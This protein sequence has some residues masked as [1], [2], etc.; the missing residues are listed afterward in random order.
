MPGVQSCKKKWDEVL[1][2]HLDLHYVISRVRLF[3][4][5]LHYLAAKVAFSCLS[6]DRFGKNFWELMTSGQV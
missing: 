6:V 5:G 3:N 1:F 2:V 4:V